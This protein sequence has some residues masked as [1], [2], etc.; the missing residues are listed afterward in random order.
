MDL[1]QE[2]FKLQD[3]KY[4]DF[5]SSLIPNIGRDRIIG[6]RLPLLRKFAKRVARENNFSFDCFYY[7]EFTVKG[8]IIGYADL[9]IEKRL[10]MLENFVP[11]IDNWAVCDCCCATYKFSSSYRKEVWDFIFP[12]LNGGEYDVRFSAVMMLQYFL[13]DDYIERVVGNLTAVTCCDY[14]AQMAVAWAFCEA[15]A[16][17]PYLI[18]PIL[19]NGVLQNRVHNFTISKICDSHR[20]SSEEKEKLK[21]LKIKI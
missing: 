21:K 17:Y 13:V 7:E 6:V 3:K 14:Y 11:S 16:K 1:R 20:V 4:A 15:Y 10:E 2:L 18:F 12:Y 9:P 19:K 8:M 5:Q